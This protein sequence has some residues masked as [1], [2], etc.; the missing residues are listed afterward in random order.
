MHRSS[1]IA[2]FL[3]AVVLLTAAWIVQK[4]LLQ[5]YWAVN[6]RIPDYTH[7]VQKNPLLRI[8]TGGD[9]PGSFF[10]ISMCNARYGRGT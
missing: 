6:S 7:I 1:I 5:I 9:M 8:D 3:G 10:V 4:P 2:T